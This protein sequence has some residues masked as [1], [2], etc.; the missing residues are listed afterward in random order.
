[1][2]QRQQFATW[3][4]TAEDIFSQVNYEFVRLPTGGWD[5]IRNGEVSLQL[6]PGYDLV[7]TKWCGICSTDLARRYLPFPLPQVIGHEVSGE[8]NGKPVVV[9]INASHAAR[10]LPEANSCPLCKND[11][12]TQCPERITLGINSL[13]GGFAPWL[14][15]PIHNLIPIPDTLDVKLACIAEPLA[16]ALHAV[17]ST[18]IPCGSSVAVLG[19]RRLGLLIIAALKMARNQ[20]NLQF[21]I[22][23]LCR[24]EE[25]LPAAIKMGADNARVADDKEQFDVVYDTTGNPAGLQAALQLSRKIVHLKSTNGQPVL[26]VQC[27]TELV[28]DELALLPFSID[29]LGFKWPEE[30]QRSNKYVFIGP[31]VPEDVEREINSTG[32]ITRRAVPAVA[33]QDLV[34]NPPEDMQF[35][36]YDLAVV[37]STA[38][39]DAVIRP[40]GRE[41]EPCLVRPRGAILVLPGQAPPSDITHWLTLGRQILSSR[42]GDLRRAINLLSRD[43]TIAQAIRDVVISKEF[44][45]QQLP[46]AFVAATA[47]ENI[48]V[49]VHTEV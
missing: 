21:S 33:M 14:L 23:A 1:M 35:G 49:I 10:G 32:R 17:T 31:A 42:C 18:P 6:G 16:A 43:D 4:Y 27:M 3:E 28:V 44:E 46:Q 13:P 9:E 25:L 37:A 15:A 48:K 5:I 45:L 24:R 22:S 12:P 29:N 11:L 26:G 34:H 30:A 36:R 47:K 41:Q 19:P 40:L 39:I 38:E 2:A 7:R 20:L 8:W